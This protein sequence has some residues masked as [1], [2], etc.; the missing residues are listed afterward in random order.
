[1][2]RNMDRNDAARSEN[3]LTD[4]LRENLSPH[5][6][7]VVAS[8]LHPVLT[9][10]AGVDREIQWLVQQLAEAVGGWEQQNR[11]AEEVGL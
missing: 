6:V 2:T 8:Y 1:M 5:A 10:D 9:K 11:L 4:A 7:A 3:A